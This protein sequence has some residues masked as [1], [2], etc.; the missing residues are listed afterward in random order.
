MGVRG[1]QRARDGARGKA[2]HKKR[3]EGWD[4]WKQKGLGP[5]ESVQQSK[6]Q[7]VSSLALEGEHLGCGVAGPGDSESFP[8]HFSFTLGFLAPIPTTDIMLTSIK[9][10]LEGRS[11][12]VDGNLF[13][14]SWHCGDLLELSEALLNSIC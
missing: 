2:E 10:F 12:S 13:W 9:C 3:G 4:R 11:S 6:V 1:Q 14:I 7:S 8:L 5:G